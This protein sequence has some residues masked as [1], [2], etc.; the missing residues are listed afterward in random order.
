MKQQPPFLQKGDKI[1]IVSTSNCIKAD[2]I[3]LVIPILEGWGLNIIY[4]RT[5][6]LKDT[7]FAGTDE[8]RLADYQNMINDPSISAILQA[9]G[10]YGCVRIMD[11]V[12]YSAFLKMSKWI[13]GYSDITYLH[14]Q[15]NH[16]LK[17][18]S[19]HCT[20]PIDISSEGMLHHS[21]DSLHNALF[22][23]D[24]QYTFT[25][26][27]LNR[28]G[29]VKGELVGGNLSIL[30]NLSGTNS[31]I[32]T[33]GKILFIEEVNE[34]FFHIDGFMHSLKKAGKF[35]KLAGLLVGKMVNI[36]QDD[37]P[38]EET[39]EEIISNAVKEYDFPVAFNFPAGHAGEN[40]A[41]RLG[42][43]ALLKVAK[44]TTVLEFKN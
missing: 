18:Q 44:E 11:K 10:G 30:I 3:K 34:H 39:V 28:T 20:M 23:E 16:E 14:N 37:P 22:G 4:G 17:V 32:N 25:A 41:I 19:I 43:V 8:E 31:D 33:D 2:E 26:H 1:A 27:P 38:F 40:V 13:C 9:R 15:L 42:A 5:T 35:D 12:D 7:F 6:H 29:Q 21:W 36:I 24:L